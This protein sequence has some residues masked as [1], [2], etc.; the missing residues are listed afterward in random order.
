[1][2]RRSNHPDKWLLDINLSKFVKAHVILTP[3]ALVVGYEPQFVLH[4]AG[5]VWIGG[6]RRRVQSRVLESKKRYM[7]FRVI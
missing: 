6:I 4:F 5:I 7:L 3:G 1:M 2:R